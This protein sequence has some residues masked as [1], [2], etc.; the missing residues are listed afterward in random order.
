[1]IFKKRL[2]TAF[3]ILAGVI[4]STAYAGVVYLESGR[5]ARLVKQLISERS[6]ER[7]GV[8]GDFS[9]LKLYFFPPGIGVENPKIKIQKE[10]VLQF[11]I[12]GDVEAKELRVRFA[13]IQMLSGTIEVSRIEVSSGAVQGLIHEEALRPQPKSKKKKSGGLSWQDVFELQVKGVL[14]EDTYLN[15]TVNLPQEKRSQA[16]AELVVKS[17]EIDK[18]QEGKKSAIVS[19]GLVNAVKIDVPRSILDIPVKDAHQVEWNFILNEDGLNLMPLEAELAGIHVRVEGQISGDL[20]GSGDLNLKAKSVLKSDLGT[21]FS[22]NLGNDDWGGSVQILA[23]VEAKLSD[24]AHTLRAQYEVDGSQLAWGEVRVSQLRGQGNL[25]LARER[26]ELKRVDLEDQR[27]PTR[28]GKMKVEDLVIPLRLDEAFNA[29][30]EFKDADLQWLGGVVASSIAPL[31]GVFQGSI[32]AKFTPG[33]NKKWTLGIS[34]D[35]SVERFALTNQQYEQV[36]P[37]KYILRPA[38]PLQLKGNVAISPEGLTFEQ[39]NIH[40][41][42]THFKVTGGIYGKEGYAFEALGPIDLA[43][44]DQISGTPIRGIGELKASIHGPSTGVVMD[45]QT[46]LKEAVYLDLNLGE[47]TGTVTYDDGISELRFS[48][49][50]ANQ[51]STFYS[52]RSGFI[53]L[54]GGDDLHL[55]IQIHSGRVEDLALILDSLVKKISWYPESLRGEIHGGVELAGKLDFAQMQILSYLEGSDWSW[56]GERARRIKMKAGYDRGIYFARDVDIT[57]TNGS[58]KGVIEFRDSTEEMDWDFVT[59]G[60]SFGDIDFLERLEIPARS[61]FEISSKGSGTMDRLKSKSEL[62]LTETEI[63]GEKLANSQATLEVS[64]RTIRALINVFGEHLSSQ[65]KYALTPKQPSSLQIQFNDLDFTPALLALNPKLLDDPSLKGRMD[66]SIKLEFLSTQSELARG[67]VQLN[68]YELSK[69]NFSL[70]LENPFTVP[71]QLGYFSVGPAH[72]RFNDKTVLTLRGEGERGQADLTLEGQVDLAMAEF[73]S[74]SLQ[75]VVGIADTEISLKG[76]F[77]E[78]RVN[79]DISFE[80]ARAQLR[81]VQTPLDHLDGN[82]R[83]RNGTLFVQDFTST[84]G[85]EELQV[86]GKI[87]TFTDRFPILDLRLQF[88][89]N[90]VKMLPLS[91]VQPRGVAFIRGDRPPYTIGGNIEVTQA[92]WSKSFAS[93]GPA[94]QRGDRFAPVALD[95]QNSTGLFVLDLQVLANQAFVIKNEIIDAEFRGKARLIGPLDDPRLLGEGQLIQGKVLFRDRPFVFESVRVDFDDPYR[96]N[97]KFNASAVSEVNQYKVK[98]LAFGSADNWK[99]EFSSTPYLAE[100]E[101]FSLLASGL[102]NA[103]NSRFRTRDRTYVSQG[104]AASLILHSLDFS[105][106][107]QSRTGFQFDVEEA[108]DNQTAASIFR[109][110]GQDQNVAS[111]KLVIKR[112]LGR[113]FD[114]SFGSTVGVGSQ[115]QREVNAEYRVTSGLSVLGVWNNIEEVN[116]RETRTSFGLDLKLNRKFK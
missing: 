83:I 10:N 77:K 111:P 14:L 100:N 102:T 33:Q 11:P 103:E 47:V 94:K 25:D 75:K 35:L 13:P 73:F 106:D 68:Q 107:V 57:K 79:G 44:I 1:M 89:N 41:K 76:P 105:R 6:P 71:I 23:Q 67:Q 5:F 15:I 26:I 54:S 90:K 63:K 115:N 74:S 12:D 9:N 60:M 8:V 49:I 2:K 66:G 114:L 64:E 92:L 38:V 42:R 81:S 112:K 52:M 3:W 24:I 40:L 93:T 53:D 56:L 87:E 39:M 86:G 91:L 50:K 46:R 78:L 88:N 58:L 104:E 62:L 116:V 31:E 20:L 30:I 59:E 108:V 28:I 29:R 34:T 96:L 7:L 101:I 37:K 82:V 109:P 113:K 19:R 4:A 72:F 55:P 22:S 69:S 17:L 95:R 16:S 80:D 43:D 48:D 45:F 85:D 32:S 98:V 97:P 61:K 51:R 27:S 18:S 99:A 70:R 65:V 110:Q 21:F 36:K 84:F